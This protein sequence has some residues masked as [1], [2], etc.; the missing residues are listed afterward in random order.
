[1]D[2]GARP[3]ELL[4]FRIQDTELDATVPGI[5]GRGKLEDLGDGH[6]CRWQPRLKTDTKGKRRLALSATGTHAVGELL[7]YDIDSPDNLLIPTRH[8]QGWNPNNFARLW[9]TIR[10]NAYAAITPT[11]IRHRIATD[12]RDAKSIEA[13][14]AQLG[15]SPLVA[16]R[17]YATRNPEVDNCTALRN[18]LA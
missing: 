2:T 14:A 18:R 10:G 4:G 12:I 16:A 8:G 17:Y 7:A 11:Q 9:R 3:G 6:G 13:A 1:M 15:N 5:W